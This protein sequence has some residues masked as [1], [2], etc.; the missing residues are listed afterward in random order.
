MTAHRNWGGW[1]FERGV[2]RHPSLDD[3]ECAI[4]L[5]TFT[6][7]TTVLTMIMSLAKDD[8]ASDSC[9]AGL[10]RALRDIEAM[11]PRQR[12]AC[13]GLTSSLFVREK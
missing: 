1:Q 4:N 9:I 3:V 5:I 11:T 10:V 13:A 2:L 6:S 8:R 12:V 7:A